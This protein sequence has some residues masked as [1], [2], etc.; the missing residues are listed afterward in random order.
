MSLRRAD[1]SPAQAVPIGNAIGDMDSDANTAPPL[2]ETVQEVV[3]DHRSISRSWYRKIIVAWSYLDYQVTTYP[4]Y[5]FCYRYFFYYITETHLQMIMSRHNLPTFWNR[6]KSLTA[7]IWLESIFHPSNYVRLSLKMKDEKI[8]QDMK[9]RTRLAIAS[10]RLWTLIPRHTDLPT[11]LGR[12][13]WKSRF[14]FDICV[15]WKLG[16]HILK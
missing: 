10:I 2:R 9:S 13:Q 3:E 16:F 11:H 15:L 1:A 4:F 5:L 8:I 12:M 7:L 6:M 14:W